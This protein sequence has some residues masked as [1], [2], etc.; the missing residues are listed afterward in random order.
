MTNLECQIQDRIKDLEVCLLENIKLDDSIVGLERWLDRSEPTLSEDVDGSKDPIN[1]LNTLS[2]LQEEMPNKEDELTN[3]AKECTSPL[4]SNVQWKR[5]DDVKE[6]IT[7]V[8][9]SLAGK[10]DECKS[11][12]EEIKNNQE[13]LEECCKWITEAEVLMNSETPLDLEDGGM[14]EDKIRK[15]KKLVGDLPVYEDKVQGILNSEVLQQASERDGDIKSK[16]Q[17]LG[18]QIESVGQNALNTEKHLIAIKQGKADYV[19]QLRHC[20]NLFDHMKESDSSDAEFS[21]N[22]DATKTDLEHQKKQVEQLQAFESEIAT[23]DEASRVIMECQ[24]EC[25]HDILKNQIDGIKEEWQTAKR[26]ALMKQD[27]TEAWLADVQELNKTKQTCRDQ[28]AAVSKVLDE[29]D[30]QPADISGANHV[31]GDLK[32]AQAELE[33]V[34]NELDNIMQ[35]GG[36][37]IDRS[38]VNEQHL[39]EGSL[40]DLNDG[41]HTTEERIASEIAEV[42]QKIHDFAKFE[43]DSAHCETMLTIYKAAMPA[44]LSCTVETLES[45]MEKLRRLHADM[46]EREIHM[47]ALKEQS[48]KFAAEH[49]MGDS[50][51]SKHASQLRDEWGNLRSQLDEKLKEL[52]HLSEA[53]TDFEN[54]Y[55]KRLV[56]I[57]ELERASSIEEGPVSE[58]IEQVQQLFMDIESFQ[59]DLDLLTGRAMEIPAVA[60]EQDDDPKAKLS[61]LTYR[62]QTT[63]NM[64]SDLVKKFEKEQQNQQELNE[65]LSELEQWT[66]DVA[67]S[68][69]SAPCMDGDEDP[70]E[71]PLLENMALECSLDEKALLVDRLS[72]KAR[73]MKNDPEKDNILNKLSR[74]AQKLEE[75]RTEVKDKSQAI[76]SHMK[77]LNQIGEEIGD[78]RFVID[79]IKASLTSDVMVDDDTLMKEKIEAFK[80]SLAKLELCGSQL[81]RAE[82][83]ISEIKRSNDCS[84]EL[85]VETELNS[86]K[87]DLIDLQVL[88]KDKISQLEQ[89]CAL[90]KEY[91]EHLNLCKEYLAEV[92]DKHGAHEKK[93]LEFAKNR[94]ETCRGL[95]RKLN[96]TD[97]QYHHIL[98]QSTEILTQLPAESKCLVQEWV[99]NLESTRNQLQRSLS[100]LCE[101]LKSAVSEQQSLEDWMSETKKL[102]ENSCELL[103]PESASLDEATVNSRILDLQVLIPKLM[104]SQAV[105]ENIT[106][107]SNSS[108]ALKALQDVYD[109]H[110]RLENAETALREF[111]RLRC[112][113]EE[114]TNGLEEILE[115]CELESVP[116]KSV[117]EAICQINSYKVSTPWISVCLCSATQANGRKC[118]SINSFGKLLLWIISVF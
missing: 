59:E 23:L 41:Y 113:F 35:N 46:D 77:E 118:I 5:L 21:L 2:I 108:D 44:E 100:I 7:N 39:L 14:V 24:P 112:T 19:N 28:V 78:H 17:N 48:D 18:A 89:V 84:S 32:K 29:I 80:D 85:K 57:E 75:R 61:V 9:Q 81:P 43:K 27:E 36:Q 62:W 91:V 70:F 79:D 25:S 40:K 15:L 16:L 11:K 53:K 69:H 34:K 6:R 42:Q 22:L 8:K 55:S 66:V 67:L 88:L 82:Q 105:G 110:N 96:K 65:E 90:E 93:D 102:I 98:T 104:D 71:S 31:L 74:L 54:E 10:M 26:K 38:N 52:K 64:A 1:S 37:V 47:V 107:T 33:S 101:S 76:Q 68:I 117:T 12:V 72:V 51:A 13:Q 106:Q 111:L 114:K 50:L 4:L 87:D 45:Q 3:I 94:L 103:K 86:T 97:D 58:K 30:T 49:P 63:K 20:T 60:Y 56:R 95:V 92:G 99:D 116:P 115:K 109:A 83:L 73:E